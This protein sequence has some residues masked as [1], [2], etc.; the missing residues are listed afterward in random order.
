MALF[1]YYIRSTPSITSR[2]VRG[3]MKQHLRI[4]P[5]ALSLLASTLLHAQDCF[6]TLRMFA[7]DG[8]GWDGSYVTIGSGTGGTT[9]TDY[10]LT[11]SELDVVI[12]VNINDL[13]YVQYTPVGSQEEQISFMI[14]Y[15][16]TPTYVSSSPPA[17]GLLFA[18]TVSCEPPPP[19]QTDCIGAFTLFM[20]MPMVLDQ[21]PDNSGYIID[22]DPGNQGCLE[23]GENRGY[24]YMLSQ[25]LWNNYSGPYAFSITPHPDHPADYDFALWGPFT[26]LTCPPPGPPIRCSF[27]STT[28]S[29]G[30]SFT[31]TDD[32]DADGDGWASPI[33]VTA[34]DNY[35]LYIAPKG[36]GPLNLT[37]TPNFATTLDTRDRP[38]TFSLH[39][40][41][42]HDRS[43]ITL[44]DAAH[45]TVFLDLH[46]AAGRQ[47]LQQQH[48]VPA[49]TTTFELDLNGIQPG[50]YL[51]RLR[52]THGAPLGSTR[53][54]KH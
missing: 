40:N 7:D 11:G 46:D 17:G 16:G 37:F 50:A 4:M 13:F 3:N 2:C 31:A 9:T 53:L 48:T 8:N 28:G 38:G 39:P 32:W 12:G 49:G 33:V 47:V 52:D 43:T 6:Y 18:T 20:T 51:L 10:T 34:A 44:R 5:L 29:T 26:G 35:M 36:N 42:A 15:F 25:E 21:A 30:L 41:P 54:L 23:N 45:G 22:L 1:P 14:E 27:A 24:W 19:P